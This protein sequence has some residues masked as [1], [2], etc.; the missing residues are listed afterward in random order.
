[1]TVR[2]GIVGVGN[3]ADRLASTV[4]ALEGVEL[5]ACH[6][7]NEASRSEFARRHGI[8][9]V[10][11]LEGFTASGCDGVLVAT[12]HTTHAEIVVE[13]AELGLGV[14]VEKP[15]ALTVADAR[16]CVAAAAA[17]GVVL[18][19]AH[20]RRRHGA[21]R[22]LRRMIDDGTVGDLHLVEGHFSRR[23]SVDDAR[24]WR[25]DP[26]EAPSGGM[27]A[28]GVHMADNLLYL[29]GPAVRLSSLSTRI[30]DGTALTDMDAALIEFGSG[31]V[32]VLT[33]SLRIPKLVTTTVHGSEMT[34]WSEADGTRLFTLAADRLD[35]S[36]TEH[37]VEAV[38]G[39]AANLAAFAEAIRNGTP[40]ETDGAAGL[41]VVAILEAMGISA[42]NHGAPVEL[43]SL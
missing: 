42:A 5:V 25:N 43:A 23:W 40:P 3:W 30:G 10:A 7:R 4:G 8:D 12:P 38:D 1:M 15:L 20:Y 6:S 33:T 17:A 39:V 11:S 35:E 22:A 24:Q 9:V 2:L 37:V 26:A 34:A 31:A 27:T 29:A 14:M 28:L 19:V 13:L 41:A 16:R 21:T 32:G 36:R 18:Q